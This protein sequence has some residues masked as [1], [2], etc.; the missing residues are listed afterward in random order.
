MRYLLLFFL[1]YLLALTFPGI[2]P[3]NRIEPFVLGLPF[4]FA[5]VILWVVLGWGALAWRY[6][7]DRRRR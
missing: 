6:S 2:L 4:S 7:V 5:W 3:F 1:V